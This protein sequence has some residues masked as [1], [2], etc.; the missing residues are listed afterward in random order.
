M[1]AKWHRSRAWDDRFF[2]AWARPAKFALRALSSITLAV[3]L[4]T[5]VLLYGV[6]ASVP[7]G[8]LALAPTFGLYL[9]SLIVAIAVLVIP[10]VALARRRLRDSS[11]GA[12]FAAT[13][14]TVLVLGGAGAAAWVFFAWPALRYD[15]ATGAG[16]RLF[17]GFVE[18]YKSTTIRRLPAFEMTEGQFYGWWP[19]RL[20]LFLFIANLVT[21]TVRRI[22]FRFVNLGVLTVHTG[23]VVLALG[24]IHYQS[25]KQEGDVLLLS[26]SSPGVPGPMVTTFMDRDDPALWVSLDGGPWSATPLIG[27]PRYNDYGAPLS[28]RTIRL[29]LPSIAPTSAGEDPIAAR[30]IGFG[31]YIELVNEWSPDK[32]GAAGVDAGP[33]LDL[34][35][36]S[37]LDAGAAAKPVAQLRLP[38]GSPKDRI[39]NLGGALFIE[40]VPP[41]DPRWP[42][43]GMPIPGG[44]AFALVAPGGAAPRVEP[45]QAG[46]EFDTDGFHIAVKSVHTSAPF[47]I[48][49][50]GYKDADSSVAIL[51]V[52]APDGS[53]FERWVFHRFP[54]LNQDIHGSKPDGRPDRRPADPALRLTLLDASALEVYLRGD[55]ALVRMPHG[56][57]ATRIKDLA[58]GRSFT[59]APHVS[60]RIDARSDHASLVERPIAVPIARQQKNFIGKHDRSAIA[61]ELSRGAWRR[62]VWLPYARYMNVA[63]GSDRRIAL[64]DGRAL[65]VAFSRTPRPLPGIGLRLADF[66]MIAYPNSDIP[67]DYLSTVQVSDAVRG[68]TRTAVTRLNHPLIHRAPFR[69]RDDRPALA[70]LLGVA[71]SFIAPNRYKFSQ[72]GWDAEGWRQSQAQ[73]EAGTLDRPRASFTILAVG[74]NPGIYVIAA[75]GIMVCV[76]IP[77]AF[78]VKP[79]LLRRRRD[80]LKRAHA[81]RSAAASSRVPAP[82]P[83]AE[84]VA[85]V[86]S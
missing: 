68:R 7:I 54:E 64:P 34:T 14:L 69:P 43:L 24:S 36:L 11:R 70:N 56:E 85:E 32:P 2:P 50:P 51:E 4:L 84:A 60:L 30:I 40:H 46:T 78:Y 65:R 44:G 86:L 66:E 71:V 73:V 62:V 37:A 58:P 13:M 53:S 16:L 49:T 28:D 59:L 12:R 23:I 45:I 48:I 42:L 31:A 20:I 29:A 18:A 33:M 15:P 19:L 55:E 5:L 47:P 82:E 21:A 72:A 1:S 80:K 25:L 9:V 83:G 17:P 3:S 41:D 35:I 38:S 76:G 57:E 77:W 61:L 67:R 63:M 6:L 75:G 74:N 26:G 81:R 39:A 27:L 10:G 79:W 52:T 22:E 8:L